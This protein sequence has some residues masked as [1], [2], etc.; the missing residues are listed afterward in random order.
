M[1]RYLVEAEFIEEKRPELMKQPKNFA[2]VG[3]GRVLIGGDWEA[4]GSFCIIECEDS[5]EEF[6]SDLARW[7]TLT[8]KP[9]AYCPSDCDRCPTFTIP[10]LRGTQT[11][12]EMSS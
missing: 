9:I 10:P 1:K 2:P 6:L 5:P 11:I 3:E 7:A 8:V 12:A 4:G